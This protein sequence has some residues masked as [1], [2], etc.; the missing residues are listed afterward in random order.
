MRADEGELRRLMIGGLDGDA[1][2]HARL[3][4]L[5]VPLLRAFLRR[6]LSGADED[7]E[8][9]VQDI[10]IAVHVRRATYDRNRPFTPWLHAV[11]RYKMGDHVRRSRRLLPI[12]GLDGRGVAPVAEAQAVGGSDGKISV[13]RGLKALMARIREGGR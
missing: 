8:D 10:V 9:L 13:R 12:D 5:L 7:I 6:R 11:A 1:A 2:D 3:L 4:R